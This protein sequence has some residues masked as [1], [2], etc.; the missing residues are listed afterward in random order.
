MK[1]LEGIIERF[2]VSITFT[3]YLTCSEG[4]QLSLIARYGVKGAQR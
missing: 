4:D 3:P 1:K 2:Q